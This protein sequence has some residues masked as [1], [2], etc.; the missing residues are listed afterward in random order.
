MPSRGGAAGQ[1][2]DFVLCFCGV[3]KSPG[4]GYPEVEDSL[5]WL[6]QLLAPGAEKYRDRTR[7][8][9][10]EKCGDAAGDGFHAALAAALEPVAHVVEVERVEDA[11]R[12]DDATAYLAHLA[13]PRYSDLAT[14]TFFLHADAPEHVHPF[15]LLEDIVV[16]VRSGTLDSDQFPF[17][18]LSHNYLDLGTS[19]HT[20]DDFASPLL[21]R[22]LFGS[23]VAPPREDV[24][25]YCCVQFLVPRPRALL[26]RQSWYADAFRWF[27]S[28]ESY[29]SLFPAGRL[30]TWQD[31]TCRAPAQLWMPWWHVVPEDLACPERH[32]DPRL[33]LFVQI[34]IRF[35]LRS[36]GDHSLRGGL[37]APAVMRVACSLQAEL[38]GL[39]C[40]VSVSAGE[41]VVVADERK[42][43]AQR[44]R[45][46]PATA[47]DGA[48][49]A[50]SGGARRAVSA[51][52]APCGW[53]GSA[54]RCRCRQALL[55]AQPSECRGAPGRG[56]SCSDD[57]A[58][59]AER[60]TELDSVASQPAGSAGEEDEP[61]AWAPPGSAACPSSA[62]PVDVSGRWV[63]NRVEGDF[64]GL[65]ADAGVSA[66]PPGGWQRASTTELGWSRRPSSRR[67]TQWSSCSRTARG[68]LRTR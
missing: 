20:W 58:D 65:M 21:W 1:T 28:Y 47:A 7:V 55:A 53:C 26:R 52:A 25:G 37:I 40:A 50:G 48:A 15:R 5:G 33:P 61:V 2:V 31:L 34:S 39:Q 32:L 18:Y 23:S 10:K 51:A 11:L 54:G 64:D 16:A 17:M 68:R 22:R 56:A 57:G 4:G 30:V 43:D 59:T 67:G 62:P 14:W 45:S 46:Q 8:F 3:S 41:E 38:L 35:P 60:S 36:S 27:A 44:Q 13:G 63:L 42:A 24:K 66:G 6:V 12:A 49:C 19:R 9:I 29:W